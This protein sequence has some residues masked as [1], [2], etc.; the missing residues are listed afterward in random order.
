MAFAPM[1]ETS[2]TVPSIKPWRK[3]VPCSAVLTPAFTTAR[4][5]MPSRV[6]LLTLPVASERPVSPRL[7]SPAIWFRLWPPSRETVVNP[8]VAILVARARTDERLPKSFRVSPILP[9]LSARL[10]EAWVTSEVK[11][12][13]AM[14]PPAEVAASPT[15]AAPAPAVQTATAI[16]IM[17][18]PAPDR[19]DSW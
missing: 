17:A 15:K 9:P 10:M 18:A 5:A 11:A 19:P 16:A 4:P 6:V 14:A 7:L 12:A 2:A 3:L 8:A 13:L 1:A